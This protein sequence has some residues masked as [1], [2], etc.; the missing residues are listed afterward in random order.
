METTMTLTA[1]P[2]TTPIRVRTRT[3]GPPIGAVPV[4]AI[5]KSLALKVVE[6]PLVELKPSD[7]NARTHSKK[8]IHQIAESIKQVGFVNPILIDADDEIVAGHGRFAAAKLLGLESAPTIRLNHLSA[9][10]IRAYRLADNRL[11]E[12]AGWDEDLLKLEL[13]HLVEIDFEVELTGFETAQIVCFG[14]QV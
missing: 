12:L 3:A 1:T 2:T 9:D 14:V 13:G 10:E 7:R 6:R 5:N 8:Q 4:N 11:A